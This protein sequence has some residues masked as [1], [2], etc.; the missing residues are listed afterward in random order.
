MTLPEPTRQVTC[1]EFR[2]QW[3]SDF[4]RRRGY[5]TAEYYCKQAYGPMRYNA[6]GDTANQAWERSIYIRDWEHGYASIEDEGRWGWKGLTAGSADLLWEAMTYLPWL[7]AIEDRQYMAPVVLDGKVLGEERLFDFTIIQRGDYTSPT[8]AGQ[9][10]S[11]SPWKVMRALAC[12]KKFTVKPLRLW[13][14]EKLWAQRERDPHAKLSFAALAGEA[15]ETLFLNAQ[16]VL[17]AEHIQAAKDVR[18]WRYL[19]NRITALM[20][21]RSLT[22]INDAFFA[23]DYHA[24]PELALPTAAVLKALRAG[25]ETDDGE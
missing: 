5:F 9:W 8:W 19:Y 21:G 20:P 7:R 2:N 18:R 6:E 14:R 4:G 1:D 12:G 25:Q 10:Y 17:R 15:N 16:D 22:R 11:V 13:I 24:V 23:V 3:E